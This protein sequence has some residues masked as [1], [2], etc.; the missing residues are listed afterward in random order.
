M[1]IVTVLTANNVAIEYEI[2]GI[3][4]RAIAT[5]ID[6]VIMFAY[7]YIWYR[8]FAAS[9]LLNNLGFT[10]KLLIYLPIFL[11]HL[12]CEL[13]LEGQSIGKKV[14][15]IRVVMLDAGRPA[16]VNYFIR[17]V[18]TPFEFSFGGA[19]VVALMVC[20][21]SGRGQR[22]ADMAAGTTVIRLKSKTSIHETLYAPPSDPNYVVQFSEVLHLTDSEMNLIKQVQRQIYRKKYD[23]AN[24]FAE[25]TKKS[26]CKKI[27]I[28]SDMDGITFLETILSDYQH[29]A[30]AHT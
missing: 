5:L 17:W 19:G 21:A 14:R 26:I 10:I 22:L 25:E 16:F 1:A 3:G 8:I 9:N 15:G 2:A 11:Y 13:F 4:D 7:F 20:A 18:I 29:L 30:T 27:N 6:W 28:T 24:F 12:L 23:Q